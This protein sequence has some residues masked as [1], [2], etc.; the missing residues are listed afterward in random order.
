[1]IF[2]D[3]MEQNKFFINEQEKKVATE[4]YKL[5]KGYDLDNLTITLITF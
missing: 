2:W 5:L 4:T 1:M 3:G